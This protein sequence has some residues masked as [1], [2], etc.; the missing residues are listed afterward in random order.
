[1]RVYNSFGIN[2]KAKNAITVENIEN[3]IDFKGTP[4]VVV[5]GKYVVTRQR[6]VSKG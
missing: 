2:I 4:T 1:M 3:G 5:N 6:N